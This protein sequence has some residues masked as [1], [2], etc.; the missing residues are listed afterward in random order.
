MVQFVRR[1]V[2][3]SCGPADQLVVLRSYARSLRIVELSVILGVLLFSSQMVLAQFSQQGPKLVG[4]GAT[5]V[6]GQGVSVSL[7][8]D[9]NTAIVGGDLDDSLAGAAWVYTR[10]GGVWT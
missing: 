6:T 7:S 1:Y 9:G 3:L 5:G 8:S 4:T 10:S 2:R